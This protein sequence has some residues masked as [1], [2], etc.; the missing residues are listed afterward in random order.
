MKSNAEIL[1]VITFLIS[2]NTSCQTSPLPRVPDNWPRLIIKDIVNIDLP[3]ILEVQ[4]G[5]Y[6]AY[7]ESFLQ[8]HGS[9]SCTASWPQ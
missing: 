5:N 9:D 4:N 8:D 7:N 6:K 1:T 3:P 2:L